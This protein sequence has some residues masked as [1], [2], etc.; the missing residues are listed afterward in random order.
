MKY[1]S[2]NNMIGGYGGA[3]ILNGC[4]VSVNKGQISVIVG[5]NGS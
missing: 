3:D 4:S 2:G 5:P 1:L